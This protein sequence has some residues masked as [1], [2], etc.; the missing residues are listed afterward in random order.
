M[1]TQST[2]VLL[3]KLTIN[4]YG[5]DRALSQKQTQ[6]AMLKTALIIVSGK[7]KSLKC[8]ESWSDG[9]HWLEFSL[10]KE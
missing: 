9:R 1:S 5:L 8:Q 2:I 10:M 6:N 7:L 3:R 4:K